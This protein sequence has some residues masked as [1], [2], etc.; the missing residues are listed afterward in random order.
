MTVPAPASARRA[1]SRSGKSA[2]GSAPS[3]TSTSILPVGGGR[4]GC[5]RR[6][7]RSARGPTPTPAAN[8]LA[9]V[10]EGDPTGQ[11]AGGQAHV[12][13]AVHVGPAQRGE[14]RAVGQAGEER[15]GG[16]GDGGRGLG[17]RRPAEDDD[18]RAVAEQRAG[19]DDVGVV[20]AHRVGAAAPATARPA[21]AARRGGTA[22]TR[23]RSAVRPVALRR[24]LDERDAVVRRTAW[25]RRR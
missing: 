22:A 3:S 14:E 2:S 6:R 16:V 5:R 13:R 24:Q 10:V 25:R 12:E 17:Q 23:R 19:A 1:R 21:P 7:G 15:G 18:Q 8:A 20:G 9:A 4:A 11:E